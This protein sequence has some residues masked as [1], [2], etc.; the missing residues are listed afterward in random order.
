MS[1]RGP[2]SGEQPGASSTMA[3]QYQRL[4]LGFDTDR[5]I[6]KYELDTSTFDLVDVDGFHNT[7]FSTVLDYLIFT[8]F[9]L[10]LSWALLAVD[11]YTCLN[12][13]V[14]HKWGNQGYTPYAYSVAKWIFTGCIIFEIL[15]AIY[16]I[17]WSIHAYRTRN[18]ALAYVNNWAKIMYSIKRYNYHCL[19]F[20]IKQDTFFDWAAF[21]SYFE[22]DNALEILIADAPRQVI[23]ILT[24]RYYATDGDF[25]QN[26]QNIIENIRTIATTNLK[27]SIILSFM[28]ASVILFAIFFV[29]FCLGMICYIPVIVGIRRRG[30][31]S[32]KK[33][34]CHIVNEKVRILVRKHHKSKKEL[35]DEGILDREEIKANPLLNSTTTFNEQTTG[36]RGT[37]WEGTQDLRNPF[38]SPKDLEAYG[39]GI[40]KPAPTYTFSNNS[41]EMSSMEKKI[42][43][44]NKTFDSPG[45]VPYRHPEAPKNPFADSVK[46]QSSDTLISASSLTYPNQFVQTGGANQGSS[47]GSSRIAPPSRRAPPPTTTTNS[48]ATY[49]SLPTEVQYSPVKENADPVAYEYYTEQSHSSSETIPTT[50]NVPISSTSDQHTHLTNN[51]HGSSRGNLLDSFYE[52]PAAV[53]QESLPYPARGSTILHQYNDPPYPERGSTI[54]HEYEQMSEQELHKDTGP[55]PHRDIESEEH[56]NENEYKNQNEYDREQEHGYYRRDYN[57]DQYR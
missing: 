42:N 20:K 26:F 51:E 13:L 30:Y 41:Y 43:Q 44:S 28:C 4:N 34:C 25:S 10:I 1:K 39:N 33:Y 19:F 45:Y 35:L 3:D 23:N 47:Y 40:V 16:H 17:S 29:K 52:T 46:N 36:Y 15:L 24:L 22:L 7:K 56:D 37:E 11:I 53:S 9:F 50:T 55:Y 18:I 12:I 21:L 14:F 8:W 6:D 48:L 57:Q 32:L 27:L 54:I 31:K 2:S 49:E 38:S 5:Q